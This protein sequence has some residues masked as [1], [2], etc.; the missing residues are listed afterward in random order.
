MYFPHPRDQIT[1]ISHGV[2]SV[3]VRCQ[4]FF[5]LEM[6]LTIWA[7]DD[8]LRPFVVLCPHAHWQNPLGYLAKPLFLSGKCIEKVS[9]LCLLLHITTILGP[10]QRLVLFRENVTS[11]L[12]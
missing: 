7:T 2:L 3:D 6:T 10:K 1:H 11:I 9:I 5:C 12:R 8:W 4:N